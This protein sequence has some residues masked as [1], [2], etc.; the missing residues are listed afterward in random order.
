ME[1]SVTEPSKILTNPVPSAL[2]SIFLEKILEK[3]TFGIFKIG[4]TVA[5]I[6][7]LTEP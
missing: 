5:G 2:I 1:K 7:V 3:P 4:I 6:I